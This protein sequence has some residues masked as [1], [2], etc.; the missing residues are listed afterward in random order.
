MYLLTVLY[1][2]VHAAHTSCLPENCTSFE[3][4]MHV[5]EALDSFACP[6]ESTINFPCLL[7]AYPD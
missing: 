3:Y 2:W 7:A 4:L 1:S 6:D 5:Q